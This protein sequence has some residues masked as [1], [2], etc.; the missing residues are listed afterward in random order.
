[1]S[2][3]T[4]RREAP[5]RRQA[6]GARVLALWRRCE[7]LPFG[8]AL[9]GLLF[10]A[11]VPY[12]GSIGATVL[13]LE[14]GHARLALR[15]RRAVRN[16]LGSIH[17]IALANLGE[18]ASGLAM[19]TALPAGVRGIVLRIECEYGKKARGPLVAEA[20]VLVP[21]VKG[22]TDHVVRAEIAD[23]SG[24]VV[25]SVRVHWRLGLVP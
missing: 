18:L 1:M 7:R 10:G 25:A 5:A 16:H 17:A 24:A 2:E 12:S 15:D 19:T 22:D 13:T 21:E 4:L 3:G 23:A 8:R 14:P 9:F 20:R 11:M 6:P